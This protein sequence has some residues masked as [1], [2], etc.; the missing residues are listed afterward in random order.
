VFPDVGVMS[1]CIIFIHKDLHITEVQ[2][3][4]LVGCRSF[5]SFLGSIA[6]GRTLDIIGRKWTI[7]LAAAVFQAG[8]A[9]MACAPS[10]AALM[11]GRLLGGVGIMVA[12]VYI[13]EITPATLRGSM[14]SFPEM[15]ISWGLLEYVYRSCILGVFFIFFCKCTHQFLYISA[16]HVH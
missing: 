7:G 16:D 3:E 11:A 6:A 8:A 15:L 4:V 14:A 1:G 12:P 9:I 10:F 13:S 2:Q 5:I